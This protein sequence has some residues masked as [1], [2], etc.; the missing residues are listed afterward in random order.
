[1][2]ISAMRSRRQPSSHRGDGLDATIF[3]CGDLLGWPIVISAEGVF[4]PASHDIAGLT[5]PAGLAGEVN[6]EIIRRE[7]RVP[8]IAAPGVGGRWVFLVQLPPALPSLPVGVG[9]ISGTARIPLPPTRVG[10]EPARWISEPSEV[11]RLVVPPLSQVLQAIRYT[12]NPRL[13]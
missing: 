4:L 1:M 2:A 3:L 13:A 8:I 10:A 5:V 11:Y 12:V 7:I 6:T 9:L